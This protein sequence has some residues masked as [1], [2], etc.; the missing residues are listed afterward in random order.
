MK[1]IVKN[2][3]LLNDCI[4]TFRLVYRLIADNSCS[5]GSI[6]RTV[7]LL[8]VRLLANILLSII[9]LE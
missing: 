7:L 2:V 3:T 5:F 4:V 8:F 9:I 1:T 6:V